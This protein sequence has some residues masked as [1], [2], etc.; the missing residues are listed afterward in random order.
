MANEFERPT[1]APPPLFIGK[2]ERDFIS[3]VTTEI[4]ERI[5]GQGIFYYPIDIER[6]NFHPLY[7]ESICK[8]FL[9]PIRVY[10]FVE[11]EGLT[12]ETTSIGLDKI[13][14]ITVKFHKRRITEDQDLFVREGDFV[15]YGDIFYEIVKLEEPNLIAGQIEHRYEISAKCIRARKGTFDAK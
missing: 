4:A 11:W 8:T 12:T 5:N 9:P 1:V 6:S 7:G 13:S 14:S 15:K 3:Q 10:C 2:K